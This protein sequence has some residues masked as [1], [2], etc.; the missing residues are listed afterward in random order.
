MF[1]YMIDIK[2]SSS[3]LIWV[4]VHLQHVTSVFHFGLFLIWLLVAS[5]YNS[6]FC[7]ETL[8]SYFHVFF[9]QSNILCL[10]TKSIM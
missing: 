2:A 10:K 1:L 8:W 3:I 6:E 9:I 7:A 5:E 4:F